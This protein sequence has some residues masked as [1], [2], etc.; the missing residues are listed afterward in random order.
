M[1]V[2]AFE[3]P[4]SK[5]E[6]SRLQL[7]TFMKAA[8]ATRRF[9][10]RFAER[11][12]STSQTEARWSALYFLSAAPEGLI[13]S[14]LAERMGVQ[15]PTLVRLLDALEGQD[16]VRRMEAPGDRRAKRVV[17]QPAG[18]EVIAEIDAVAEKMRDEVFASLSTQEIASAL[19][20]LE[21]VSQVLEPEHLRSHRTRNPN[22]SAARIHV[23]E[24]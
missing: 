19:H 17:I 15:G 23:V 6:R 16:L 10:A 24:P 12:K 9:R 7:E 3:T 22:G 11:V 13:Q 20:V 21:V 14:D 2:R 4:D 5:P 1:S 8:L 18:I